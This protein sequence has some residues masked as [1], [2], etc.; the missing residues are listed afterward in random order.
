MQQLIDDYIAMNTAG[1]VLELCQKY[2]ADDVL[3]LS[4]GEVFASSMQE[5]YEKQKGF[6]GAIK[7]FDVTLLSSS[8]AGNTVELS[9]Q[10]K[11]TAADASVT[12]FIG[13]HK[14]IWQQG[15]IIKEEYLSVEG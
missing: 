15:K 14:Q 6:V 4:N 13:K 11:M 10:Y 12:A 9:F 7:K 3:M 2:Y 8:I 5:A 1:K